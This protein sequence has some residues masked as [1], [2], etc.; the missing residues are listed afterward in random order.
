MKKLLLIFIM[1]S[2]CKQ[3]VKIEEKTLPENKKIEYKIPNIP[4]SLKE[5]IPSNLLPFFKNKKVENV[6][7]INTDKFLINAEKETYQLFFRKE[8]PI[9]AGSY[10]GSELFLMYMLFYKDETSLKTAYQ[11]IVEELSHNLDTYFDHFKGNGYVY[12]VDNKRNALVMITYSGISGYNE[13]KIIE[14]F[15]YSNKKYY[16]K[17]SSATVQEFIVWK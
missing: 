2:S 10:R 13:H 1:V 6:I 4:I 8:T 17:V 7:S 3:Q 14:K 15:I 12:L 11:N 9:K 5:D 16:D